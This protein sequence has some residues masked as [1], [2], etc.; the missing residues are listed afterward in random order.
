LLISSHDLSH[1]TEICDRIVILNK[2]NIVQDIKTT[3]S[4]LKELEEYFSV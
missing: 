2:G 3:E 4:T 1:V